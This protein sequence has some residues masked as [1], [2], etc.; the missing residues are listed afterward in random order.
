VWCFPVLNYRVNMWA[1]AMWASWSPRVSFVVTFSS[2]C[3]DLLFS[4]YLLGPCYRG[5]SSF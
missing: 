5:S 2:L 3:L 4:R 1:V